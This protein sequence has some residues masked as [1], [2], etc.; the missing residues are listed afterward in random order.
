MAMWQP[1]GAQLTLVTGPL[2]GSIVTNL[3]AEPL[4]A[5]HKYTES[6]SAIDRT[7]VLPQSSRLRW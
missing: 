6:D 7:F 3:Q 4:V 2:S 5:F 1:S